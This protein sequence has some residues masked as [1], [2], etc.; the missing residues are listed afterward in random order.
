MG[1]I[2]IGRMEVGMLPTNFYFLH[3][4]G[5]ADTIAVDPGAHGDGI[6]AE[7][8]KEK[9]TVRA[10]LLT[11]AHFD[12]IWGLAAL[13]EH[14]GAP[15]YAYEGEK[16]LC[17]DAQDNLSAMYGRACTVKPDIWLKDGEEAEAADIA[18][19]VLSTPG[20]TEGS[21]CYYIDDSEAGGGHILL[22]GDTLFQGSVGR[23]DF[24]TGSMS[25]L[26][27]SL[28]DRLLPLPDDTVVCPGHGAETVLGD[29]KAYNEY[30]AA[31][32]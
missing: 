3:R 21:C 27:R 10:I 26:V 22:S 13:R 11:H 1:K 17:A 31:G 12:H 15:V 28:H 18:F 8:E 25:A 9:L 20:H 14:T 16:H 5:S 32:Q 7:L 19:R 24:P 4:E 29:E 23:T 30:F 6:F 2:L